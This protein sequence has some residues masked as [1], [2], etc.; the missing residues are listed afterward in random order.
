M[1]IRCGGPRATASTRT[2]EAAMTLILAMLLAAPSM[3]VVVFPDRAQVTL[4]SSAKCG[5]KGQASIIFDNVTPAADGASFRAVSPDGVVLGVRAELRQHPEAFTPE[6][7]KLGVQ[8][9]K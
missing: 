7:E 1:S 8:I 4:A 9:R 3:R 2:S 6:A 5:E